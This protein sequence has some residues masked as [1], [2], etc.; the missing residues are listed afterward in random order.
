MWAWIAAGGV[1][2]VAAALLTIRLRLLVAH[3]SGPSMLP[4]YKDGDRLLAVRLRRP[5]R[6]AV[7]QVVVLRNPRLAGIRGSSRT[8]LMVKRIVAVAGEAV[9]V[10]ISGD[11]V[12][13]EH[14]VVLGDNREQSLDSRHLGVIPVD[15]IV[16]RVVGRLDH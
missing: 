9:P 6:F 1:V 14:V 12:P 15:H 2:V 13:R 16:A 8:P 7:G 5:A 4:A 11:V 10:G 3:V